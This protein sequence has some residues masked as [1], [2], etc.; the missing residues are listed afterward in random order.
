MPPKEPN[1]NLKGVVQTSESVQFGCVY[2]LG[3]GLK[4]PAEHHVA[5]FWNGTSMCGKHFKALVLGVTDEAAS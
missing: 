5:Y 4:A 2:C 1:F 3:E